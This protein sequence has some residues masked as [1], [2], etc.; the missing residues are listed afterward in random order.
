[1]SLLVSAFFLFAGAN[2]LTDQINPEMH[3][4]LIKGSRTWLAQL[5]PFIPINITA[6]QLRLFIGGL[7][8]VFAVGVL[9]PSTRRL[10]SFLLLVQM[11]V[12]LYVHFSVGDSPVMAAVA[13][14]MAATVLILSTVA[15]QTKTKTH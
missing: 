7:E 3:Q 12:A 2:K 10:C 1:V 5:K 4:L 6:D 13:A 11:C 8:V 15:K 9:L 14:A